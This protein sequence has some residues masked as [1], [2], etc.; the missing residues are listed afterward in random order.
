MSRRAKRF[1]LTKYGVV[2]VLLA[3]VA[4]CFDT[5]ARAECIALLNQQAPEGTHWSLHYDRVK[6]RR[7][8][9]LVDATGHDVSTL[10]EQSAGSST[11]SSIQTF[12]SNL[13]GVQSTPEPQE[14]LP[15]AA[16]PRKPQAR[17]ANANRPNPPAR[18]EQKSGAPATQHELT[19]PERDALFEEFLRWHESQ[20]IIGT[21]K[22]PVSR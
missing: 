4:A 1:G 8:W 14:A 15:S 18:T 6:N 12:F 2:C 10:Q 7:C 5:P 21:V 16:P 20:Q 19:Q 22:P 13:T 17:L 11:L 9:I 3:T